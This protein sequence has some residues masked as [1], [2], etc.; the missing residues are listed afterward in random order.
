V[1]LKFYVVTDLERTCDRLKGHSFA[2]CEA[3]TRL[4]SVIYNSFINGSTAL[5]FVIFFTQT[6]GLFGRMISPSQGRYLHTGEHKHRI[7]AHTDIYAL[8]GIRT[9]DPSVRA[10]EDSSCPRPRG[11][12]DQLISVITRTFPFVSD[13]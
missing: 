11:H 8:S 6:I 1:K 13:K 5:S 7:N 12:Y 10:S 4:P 2:Q 9:H 3:I